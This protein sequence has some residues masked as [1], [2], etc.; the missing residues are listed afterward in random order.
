MGQNAKLLEMLTEELD[1]MRLQ[2][3]TSAPADPEEFFRRAKRLSDTANL[4]LATRSKRKARQ[5]SEKPD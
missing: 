5:A 4:L 2:L 3:D 1:A